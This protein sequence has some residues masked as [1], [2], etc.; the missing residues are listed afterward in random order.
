MLGRQ[1]VRI[2]ENSPLGRPFESSIAASAIGLCSPWNRVART[3]KRQAMT[4]PDITF[5]AA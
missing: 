4:F 5:F 1:M 2:S 3:N